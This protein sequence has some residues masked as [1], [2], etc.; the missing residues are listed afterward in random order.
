M[1]KYF[2]LSQLN[3]KSHPF[4]I[5][6]ISYKL[7]LI[8]NFWRTFVAWNS[9]LAFTWG[10]DSWWWHGLLQ[11]HEPTNDLSSDCVKSTLLCKLSRPMRVCLTVGGLANFIVLVGFVFVM[12]HEMCFWLHVICVAVSIMFSINLCLDFNNPSRRFRLIFEVLLVFQNRPSNCKTTTSINS[13]MHYVLALE[14]L[15]V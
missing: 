1:L 10:E 15:P 11:V 9:L 4:Y 3:K 7:Q 14:D 12:Q 5:F 6:V 8:S 13:S 2:P